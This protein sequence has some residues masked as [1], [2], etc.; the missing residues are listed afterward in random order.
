M[1]N[2][3]NQVKPPSYINYLLEKFSAPKPKKDNHLKN[4]LTC[5]IKEEKVDMTK[6]IS[7]VK[8]NIKNNAYSM[9]PLFK[10]I[11][12]T[13]S[14]S[15]SRITNYSLMSPIELYYKRKYEQFHKISQEGDKCIICL[16]E[17][18]ENIVKDL[19]VDDL[20]FL[21]TYKSPDVI[22]L[23]KC[24]DHFFHKEC[25][26]NMIGKNSFIKC[27]ICLKIYGV[28]TGTQPPGTMTAVVSS[29]VK[30]LGHEKE[31]T[32]IITYVFRSGKDY[33]GT[34]RVGYLPYNKDGIKI[35]GLLKVCFDRKLVFTVGTSVTT[36]QSN[37]TV[38][39]GI[40]HKTNYCGG[41]ANFGF[42]DETYFNRVEQEMAAKGVS[43]DT[44]ENPP[45]YYAKQLLGIKVAK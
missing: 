12:I 5:D 40:H 30:L 20:D 25:M 31:S 16:E 10:G 7:E 41:S 8:E 33:T 32:I 13:S 18:N 38:W 3:S 23:S 44:L 34:S 28:Q 17:L 14:D 37:T 19:N 22:L 29:Q 6:I 27:P 24:Q 39:N 42:P 15:I 36:G 2:C 26:E 1:G 21:N 4:K 43:V 45:E 11:K 9:K 35:L